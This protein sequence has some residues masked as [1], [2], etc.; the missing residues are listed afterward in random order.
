MQIRSVICALIEKPKSNVVCGSRGKYFA[1]HFTLNRYT[2]LFHETSKLCEFCGAND[3]NHYDTRDL[4]PIERVEI[5]D[6]EY[7]DVN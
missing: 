6:E 1:N 5:C 7:V 3:M 4:A 2:R